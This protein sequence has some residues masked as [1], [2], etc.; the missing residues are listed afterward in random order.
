MKHHRSSSK[1]VASFG[2][3]TA[4]LAAGPVGGAEPA[5]AVAELSLPFGATFVQGRETPVLRIKGTWDGEASRDVSLTL[6]VTPDMPGQ[7]GGT[8][9]S[10]KASVKP[11]GATEWKPD[12]LAALPPG[13]YRV[14]GTMTVGGEQLPVDARFA[15][16]SPDLADRAQDKI[17]QWVGMVPYL[18]VLDRS[19]FAEAFAYLHKTGV[20]H[21]RWLPGWG[22]I[23]PSESNYDWSESDYFMSLVEQHGMRAMFCLSYF[24]P[25][26]TW[27]KYGA[28]RAR[29]PEGRAAWVS[30]FAVPT[31][32][33]YGDRVKLWQIWNEPD[34]FW[35]E[36]PK[37]ATGFAVNFATPANYFDLLK[38]TH[39]AAHALEI[40][41]LRV[42]ASLASADIPDSTK[43][44]LGM[45]LKDLFDGMI[46]HT[47]GNHPKHFQ[48]LDKQLK[49]AGIKSPMIGSGETGL[50]RSDGDPA[51]D[52]RQ[53]QKVVNVLFSSTTIPNLLCCDWFVL[54]D[55]VAG[56]TFG[57]LDEKM[58]PHPAATAY[59]TA[60]RLLSGATSG[61]M[62]ER[63]TLNTYRVERDGRPPV[64]AVSN[65]G[66]PTLVEFN[67]SGNAA[68]IVWDIYG[69]PTT[70]AVK[71]GHFRVELA[72]AV[73]VE[74]DVTLGRAI[75]PKVGVTLAG[76]NRVGVTVSL[77]EA[78]TADGKASLA[79]ASL[80]FEQTQSFDAKGD[81]AFTLPATVQ[82]GTVYD[83]QLTLTLA[84]D[85]LRQS[86]P[87]EFSP[88]YRVTKAEADSL[89]PPA[90]LPAI[91]LYTA[92]AFR[93]FNKQRVYGGPADNSA[94]VRIGWTDSAFVL[95]VE[96]TDDTQWPI[97]PQVPNP[98]GYDSVQWSF[99]TEANLTPGANTTE[100]VAGILKEG[101]ASARVLGQP[102]FK[103]TI[104]ATR[105]GTVTRYRLT[106]SASQLGLTPKPGLSLGMAVNVND[107]DGDGRKGW[108]FWG[109]GINGQKNA[110]LHRRVVLADTP[111]EGRP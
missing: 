109:N 58:Q 72:G 38:R 2:V 44:L 41:G 96:Q 63:G 105:D 78:P 28:T 81:A 6:T 88:V 92:A 86:V 97:P 20:R 3:L 46:I 24:G 59:A 4:L 43:L 21:V 19:T 79:L 9:L 65:A 98:F 100:I 52:I 68:P 31:I 74:G 51:S 95:W 94:T 34:A 93:P 70:P 62:A 77:G 36:D 26:W 8:P 80:Q 13:L 91:K 85:T 30:D 15:V 1:R 23:E 11:G 40:P 75:A 57:L 45:G 53:A 111:P 32:K 76:H 49:A 103:P 60:A 27:K 16:M 42:M 17:P 54:H 66:T 48:L 104:E 14:A 25:E 56:G 61:T 99:Q 108:L 12:A 102:H 69:R 7:S 107:N 90:R 29:T 37:K 35:N 89:T 33:R 106:Q 39:A 10:W 110:G 73:M 82:P 71:D 101:G 67:V 87:V 50:P 83:A 55:A 18:N 5:K 22:R 84:G 47:Y 64:I